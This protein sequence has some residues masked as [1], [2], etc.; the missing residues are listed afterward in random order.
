MTTKKLLRCRSALER[1]E[2]QLKSGVKTKTLLMKSK[3]AWDIENELVKQGFSKDIIYT[4]INDTKISIVVPLIEK[5]INRINKEINILKS[6]I[7]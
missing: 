6:K 5:D 1:L 4:Q 7:K 3:Y 2:A